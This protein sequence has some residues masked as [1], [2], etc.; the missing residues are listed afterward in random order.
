MDDFGDIFAQFLPKPYFT[1]SNRFT[2]VDRR[3]NSFKRLSKRHFACL[4]E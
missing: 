1:T 4:T 2:A 3:Q